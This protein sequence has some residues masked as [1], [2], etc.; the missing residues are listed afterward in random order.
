MA[1]DDFYFVTKHCTDGQYEGVID[2][3]LGDQGLG[4]CAAN[5]MES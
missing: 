2:D 1:P 5:H 4:H 3:W